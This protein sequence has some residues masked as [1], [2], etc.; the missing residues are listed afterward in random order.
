MKLRITLSIQPVG[1]D[2]P[3]VSQTG[4]ID[5]SMGILSIGGALSQ[6]L[7]ACWEQF[8]AKEPTFQQA[9]KP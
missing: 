5:S 6:L 8:R 4:V 9:S 1:S 2:D 3:Q 7:A